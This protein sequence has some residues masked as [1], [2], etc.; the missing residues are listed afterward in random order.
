VAYPEI[1][2]EIRSELDDLRTLAAAAF[3]REE[4]Q[5]AAER[6]HQIY[7]FLVTQQ[8]RY[9]TR[10]HKG[11]E[12]HNEGVALVYLGRS[13]EGVDRIL[14][15][16]VEDALSAE[17]GLEDGIDGSPAGLTLTTWGV[18][19]EYLAAIKNVAKQRKLKPLIGNRVL[20]PD[21]T[22]NSF[23]QRYLRERVLRLFEAKPRKPAKGT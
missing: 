9:Q 18:P 12:L 16:Y 2:L 6:L 1:P 7:E 22:V 4:W 3:Q 23:V 10:F 8:R 11:W 5:T 17:T 13:I 20:Y 19:K 15:A 21:G 14:V